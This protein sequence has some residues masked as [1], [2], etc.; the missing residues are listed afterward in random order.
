MVGFQGQFFILDILSQFVLLWLWVEIWKCCVVC[1]MKHRTHCVRA[2]VCVCVCVCVCAQVLRAPTCRFPLWPP[3]GQLARNAL[4]CIHGKSLNTSNVQNDTAIN[5]T[6]SHLT[7]STH[8]QSWWY[9]A[10][11]PLSNREFESTLTLEYGAE[12]SCNTGTSIH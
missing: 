5:L 1:Y 6:S 11:F 7:P 10:F 4:A 12:Q 8:P 2:C 3:W 9:S